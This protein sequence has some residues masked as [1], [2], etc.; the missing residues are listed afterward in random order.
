VK[1]TKSGL[2]SPLFSHSQKNLNMLLKIWILKFLI[3]ALQTWNL[4]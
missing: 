3:I 1:I 4:Y 2:R